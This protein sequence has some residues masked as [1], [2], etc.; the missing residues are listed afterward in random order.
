MAVITSPLDGKAL[1]DDLAKIS[2]YK[3]ELAATQTS[4]ADDRAK[5]DDDVAPD[6]NNTRHDLPDI[7]NTKKQVAVR[8]WLWLRL[9]TTRRR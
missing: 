1:N 9:R 6:M 7:R 4:Y 3:R 2:D 8:P 5:S